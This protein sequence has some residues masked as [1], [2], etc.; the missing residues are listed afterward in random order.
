MTIN[1]IMNCLEN[2]YKEIDIFEFLNDWTRQSTALEAD[3]SLFTSVGSV[4]KVNVQ[5][6]SY[7]TEDP[8]KSEEDSP[9]HEIYFSYEGDPDNIIHK[10][11]L[12]IPESENKLTFSEIIK[13][14]FD[15][16]WL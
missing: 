4:H 12:E 5:A 2:N 3:Y 14:D 1:E 9:I 16:G 6:M 11:F 7:K 13:L 10:A 15:M 8:S